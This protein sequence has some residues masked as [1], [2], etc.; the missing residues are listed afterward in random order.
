MEVKLHD[1][2]FN[3]KM[4]QAGIFFPPMY[5][6]VSKDWNLTECLAAKSF[7]KALT[8]AWNPEEAIK[9]FSALQNQKAQ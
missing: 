1:L 9:L 5:I 6:L 3:P 4:V 7:C 2:Y 8:S